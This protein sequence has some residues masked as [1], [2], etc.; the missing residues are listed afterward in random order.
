MKF[1]ARS[2]ATA[3]GPAFATG[4]SSSFSSQS[5]PVGAICAHTAFA[6]AS[7]DRGT[8]AQSIESSGF[9]GSRCRSGSGGFGA[10]SGGTAVVVAGFCATAPFGGVPHAVT[11][12]STRQRFITS[13][14]TREP[15]TGFRL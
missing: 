4:I 8:V 15:T 10:A 1:P 11:A 3:S 5:A 2:S 14:E 12:I 9:G 13:M 7:V 6:S